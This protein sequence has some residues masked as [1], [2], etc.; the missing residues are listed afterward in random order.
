LLKEAAAT[1]ASTTTTQLFRFLADPDTFEPQLSTGD[2]ATATY[3][4]AAVVRDEQC[5]VCHREE[6]EY[7]GTPPATERL[8]GG[9]VQ[10]RRPDLDFAAVAHRYPAPNQETDAD[11]PVAVVDTGTEKNRVTVFQD[12]RILVDGVDTVEEA[13]SLAAEYVT[14]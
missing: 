10:L 8:C 1:A 12:G 6:Y 7:L 14:G 13:R 3:T 4:T 5:R 11:A 9:T 2:L